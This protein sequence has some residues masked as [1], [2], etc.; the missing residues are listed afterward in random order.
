[1]AGQRGEGDGA[2]F[3]WIYGGGDRGAPPGDPEPTR[4]IPVQRRPGA[5]PPTAPRPVVGSGRERDQIPPHERPFVP[6]PAPGGGYGAGGRGASSGGYAPGRWSRPRT[7]VRLVIGVLVLWLV[8][9]V[10]TPL[11][12]WSRVDKV[13]YE[14]RNGRPP[15]QPGT[16]YLLVGSDSRAGLSAAER[17]RLST[18]NAKSSLTDTIMLLH[19]GS[20]PTTLISIPRDSPLDIPGHG[21]G[22]VNSA[23]AKGGTPL[24]V[25]TLEQ[26]TGVRIDGYV[27]IGFGGLVGVVD[28]VGGIQICPKRAIKDKPSGLN[29]RKGCQQVDGRTALAYSRARKYS[30]I[31]DLARVQQ[32]REV[33]AAVGDKVLGPRSVLDPV[34]W[35][36]LNNAVPDFFRFG[37]GMSPIS[38]GRWALAMASTPT[39]CTVPLARADATW[40]DARA[41]RLFATVA[42][43]RTD[44][45]TKAE[46]TATGLAP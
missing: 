41:A 17:K 3:D 42:E 37:E 28:A 20:G 27:E 26:A 34:R 15:E 16:T 7:Y 4:R 19:T 30:R 1:M 18:G 33:V 22:K 32:Q 11:L 6:P 40:D 24:L 36:K 9:L 25:R 31:S 21:R 39:S 2:E 12:A 14:P 44:E 35:W 13:A 5:E 46:C 23:Y 10:G 45:I 38:A 29:V 43:D 8:F